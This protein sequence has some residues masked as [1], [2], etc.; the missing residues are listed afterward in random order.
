MRNSINLA[1]THR[2]NYK[3][4]SCEYDNNIHTC[5]GRSLRSH[6]I[7][8]MKQAPVFDCLCRVFC[9]RSLNFHI[10]IKN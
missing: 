5:Q 6:E 9:S 8:E 3:T 10:S 2:N 4:T 7:V 1:I